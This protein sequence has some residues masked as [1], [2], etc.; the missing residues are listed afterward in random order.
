LQRLAGNRVATAILA[1]HERSSTELRIQRSGDGED[2][3][4]QQR[5]LS[6][7]IARFDREGL[8]TRFLSSTYPELGLELSD[9]IS[10]AYT[11][12][13]RTLRLPEKAVRSDAKTNPR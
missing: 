5:Q 8:P 1:E 6:R 4:E 7:M 9:E 11:F 3:Q 12:D 2:R 10:P 13:T